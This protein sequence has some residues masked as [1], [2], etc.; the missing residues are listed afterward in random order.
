LPALLAAV[1][2]AA[3]AEE[4]AGVNVADMI[5]ARHAVLRERRRALDELGLD[6]LVAHATL[7]EDLEF[8]R[9][10]GAAY[11]EEINR[12]SFL[13]RPRLKA[14]LYRALAAVEDDDVEALGAAVIE[15]AD[16]LGGKR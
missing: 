6:D 16:V 8:V 11:L 14:A 2:V 15:V 1:S 13:P 7:V 3:R 10:V 12:R 5:R 9:D 4:T